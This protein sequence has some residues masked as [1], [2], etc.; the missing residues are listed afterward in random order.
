MNNNIFNILDEL[1]QDDSDDLDDESLNNWRTPNKI[2]SPRNTHSTNTNYTD[3]ENYINKKKIKLTR[4]K[5][6]HKNMLC[7][8]IISKNTCHYGNKCLYAHSLDEQKMSDIRKKAF[9]L[10]GGEIDATTVNIYINRDLYKTLL[11]MCDMC[12]KCSTG[13]CTGGYNCREGV[14]DKKY[15]VCRS[16]LNNGTCDNENCKKKHLSKMG[17]KPYFKY[18]LES[19]KEKYTKE[20]DTSIGTLLTADFFKNIKISNP[21]MSLDDN[22]DQTDLTSDSSD[23]YNLE[24]SIFEVNL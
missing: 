10:I 12:D 14:Y 24:S 5:H 8:N 16:D 1:H 3:I 9:Q 6:K 13:N 15:V 4:E 17:L 20:H 7:K 2:L 18:I 23:E 19:Q 22:E 11:S 21:H